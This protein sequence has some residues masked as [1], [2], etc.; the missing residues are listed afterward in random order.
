MVDESNRGS[1]GPAGDQDRTGVFRRGSGNP[2]EIERLYRPRSEGRSASGGAGATRRMPPARE[3][4][5]GGSSGGGRVYDGSGRQ[6]RD[7]ER[8]RRRRRTVLVVLLILLL[9][10]P[11]SFYLWA[12]SQLERVD[13][14]GYEGRPEE[15]P[16]TTYLIVGTDGREGLSEEERQALGTGDAEGKRTDTIMVL[17]V[18]D[19]GGQ[20]TII[21]VP[22]DSL[23]DVPE[24]GETKI[25]AAFAEALGGGPSRLAKTFEDAS[26]V[27]I[28]HY[29]EIGMGGFV[30]IVDSVGGVEMCPEEAIE[31]PKANLDI[32]AGCQEMDGATALG[33][34]RTRATPNADLDR[35]K[36]QREFFSTL[37]SKVTSASTLANPFRSVPLVNEGTKTFLVNEDDHLRHLASMGLAMRDDPAT[38]SVPVGSTPTL[39]TVGSVVIWDETRSEEMFQAMQEGAEI[40]ESAM[41][42]NF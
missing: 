15:Q 30:Q 24:V 35:V 1:G 4:R 40:P 32:E 39:D 26:G 21:S 2:D 22:R 14:L 7:R 23:V 41:E 18:P 10:I 38:T 29:V 33:Y 36:R 25:N 19:D 3:D 5:P 13:A 8:R 42:T 12:D 16:G 11:G 6:R 37:I 17:Y 34:V 27:H 31:D 20:S 9:V 28:D